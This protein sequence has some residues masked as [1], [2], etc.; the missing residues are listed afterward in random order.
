M[1]FIA[2]KMLYKINNMAK[3]IWFAFDFAILTY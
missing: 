3:K 2:H 1:Y